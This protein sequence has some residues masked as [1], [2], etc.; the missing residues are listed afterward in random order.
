MKY[1][2][3]YFVFLLGSLIALNADVENEFK[4]K[5]EAIYKFKSKPVLKK[6]GDNYLIKFESA[7]YCDV[8][9]AIEDSTG[10]ILR[11]LASGV[12]GPNAPKPFQKRTKIQSIP[13]NG[14]ND[15]GEYIKNL[16]IKTI[17]VSLGLKPQF[18]RTMNWEP[19]KP[20]SSRAQLVCARPEGVYVYHSG[21]YDHL[22]FYD[23]N[24]N[25]MKTI[26]PFSKDNIDKIKGL[27]THKFPHSGKTLPLKTGF[28]QG[29]LLHPISAPLKVTRRTQSFA[30]SAMAIHGD[31]IAL[32]GKTLARLATDG[33]TGGASMNGPNISLEVKIGSRSLPKIA[34]PWSTAFSPDGKYIYFSAIGWRYFH[35]PAFDWGTYNCILRMEY[36]KNSKPTLFLGSLKKWDNGKSN[37]KFHTLAGIAI[38]TK[39]RIYVSDHFNHRIQVYSQDKKYL[40]TISTERPAQISIHHK[41]QELY[42][43]SFPIRN[44]KMD[45][46]ESLNV[47]PSVTIFSSFE[48]GAKK[49]STHLLP[50]PE[51]SAVFSIGSPGFW[52]RAELDSWAKTPTIWLSQ[53]RVKGHLKAPWHK[54]GTKL[55]QIKNKKVIIIRDFGDEVKKSGKR[56][57]PPAWSRQR[58]YTNPANG[59]V[60]LAEG[61]GGTGKSFRQLIE[62]NPKT[63]NNKTIELPFDAEDICFD[64]DG[65]IYLRTGKLVARYNTKNWKEIPWDYGE[66]RQNVTFD[67]RKANLISAL[68]TSGSRT[69]PFWHLG[70][71]AINPKGHLII[72]TYNNTKIGINNKKK[73]FPGSST[74]KYQPSNFIGRMRGR[75]IHIFDK[76][77]KLLLDDVMPGI[78]HTN[79]IG[80]DN[81]DNIY[82]MASGSRLNN[83]KPYDP[84]LLDDVSETIIKVKPKN[85]KVISSGKQS[86]PLPLTKENFPKRN[87]DIVA[88]SAQASSG[89]A[90]IEGAE[91]MYGGVG[92]AGMLAGWDSGGCCC[93]N[94][95]FE[96]DYFARSFA[97][98]TRHFSIAVLDSN[99]N[100]ITRVGQYGNVEDGMPSIKQGSPKSVRSIGGDEVG[101]FHAPFLS[102]HT[103]KRLFIADL[104]NV[105][106]LSVKLNYHTEERI[107]LE[108]LNK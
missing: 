14:K 22:K 12:L 63:G 44:L 105:R 41:T 91:W 33:T 80:I 36:K 65:H 66:E 40:T 59:N 89:R 35:T 82:V 61:D 2:F 52:Y 30:A 78:G 48:S 108:N 54:F 68:I 88:S 93:W 15:K 94:A 37:D 39:G 49:K 31:K 67:K 46:K 72:H 13:W 43:F 100:L 92:F 25:Y 29:S 27:R 73:G 23:H 107:S 11:H 79:G 9:I 86:V 87:P 5:R 60:Y 74:K 6:D 95:R 58:L 55:V 45:K 1:Y 32:A 85:N 53:V 102:V 57:N 76:H 64:I 56:V 50:L 75:E 34:Q 71:M 84:T 99:G 3:I 24:G 69:N 8:T 7:G 20:S 51:H 4:I 104:G 90:W 47:K 101:L 16:N 83:G 26:Y 70:G 17:R 77:G 96:L 106:I 42:V 103:D 18:E 97:P 38:D 21:M 62:L 10:K 19:K 98:E 81:D 28:Y